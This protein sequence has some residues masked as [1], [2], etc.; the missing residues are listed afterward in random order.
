MTM[1]KR[2]WYLLFVFSAL[3]SPMVRLHTFSTT[4]STRKLFSK[5]YTHAETL[6]I[7]MLPH[8]VY[9]IYQK[10]LK[11]S[12]QNFQNAENMA[13]LYIIEDS[14]SRQDVDWRECFWK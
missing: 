14:L 5:K 8:V 13:L 1:K 9:T 3:Y 4:F 11:S 6:V 12:A 7:Q 10:N 2:L